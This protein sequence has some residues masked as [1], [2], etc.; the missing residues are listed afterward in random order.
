MRRAGAIGTGFPENKEPL[1]GSCWLP[2][3][4]NGESD[5]SDVD[6]QDPPRR[7]PCITLHA[8]HSPVSSLCVPQ[9]PLLSLHLSLTTIS[10]LYPALPTIVTLYKT[11]TTIA[12]QS[13]T[14]YHCLSAFL[15]H[16]NGHAESVLQQQQGGVGANET[17]ASRHQHVSNTVAVCTELPARTGNGGLRVVG[18]M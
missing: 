15:T 13:R 2:L 6:S 16:H 5:H 7:P 14:R 12:T 10:A 18:R 4:I 3:C 8:A 9:S 17:C 1:V 11:L